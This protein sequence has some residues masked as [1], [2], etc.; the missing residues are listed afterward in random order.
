MIN[1]NNSKTFQ[2]HLY[3]AILETI[4]L[5][6]RRDDQNEGTVTSY[7]LFE[8]RHSKIH[9][10]SQAILGDMS[11]GD[12]VMWHIPQIQLDRFGI[13]HIN[14]LDRIVDK[15]GRT[16]E[17]EAS[18]EIRYQLLENHVCISCKRLT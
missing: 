2:R 14:V 17:P 9:K 12:R 10:N 15:S 16:W 11:A 6:K 4:T 8:C 1:K 7:K 18:T 3:G 13:T 5:L